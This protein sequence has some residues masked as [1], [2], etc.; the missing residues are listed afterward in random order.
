MITLKILISLSGL[1]FLVTGILAT[2]HFYLV[3]KVK[4]Q[5]PL[6]P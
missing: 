5:T 2:D 4:K 1:A 3:K 6:P